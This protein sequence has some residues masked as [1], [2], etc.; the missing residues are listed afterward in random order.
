MPCSLEQQWAVKIPKIPQLK[1]Y[2]H[3]DFID[4]Y[5]LELILNPVYKIKMSSSGLFDHQI[6]LI[7]HE[8][9]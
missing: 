3:V 9:V 2:F 5:K 1:W 8:L 4:T 7:S 6:D